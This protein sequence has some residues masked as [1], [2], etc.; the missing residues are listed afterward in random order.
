MVCKELLSLAAH[1]NLAVIF[2]YGLLNV[3]WES[4]YLY[5]STYQR[6]ILES[7]YTPLLVIPSNNDSNGR[8][9]IAILRLMLKK[10][11][12]RKLHVAQSR[13]QKCSFTFTL[14]SSWLFSTRNSEIHQLLSSR[15]ARSTLPSPPVSVKNIPTSQTSF[16]S[17]F[18]YAYTRDATRGRHWILGW[19]ELLS[20]AARPNFPMSFSVGD[21]SVDCPWNDDINLLDCP[22]TADTIT[23][24]PKRQ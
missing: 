11:I 13:L 10:S 1:A 22:M 6:F 4:Q 15:M 3:H 17:L 23:N 12:R 16:P 18:C 21:V 9:S 14:A 5:H 19:K 24:P 8:V 20:F 2:S 7:E